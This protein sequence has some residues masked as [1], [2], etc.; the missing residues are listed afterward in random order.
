MVAL[1]PTSVMAA[2]PEEEVLSRVNQIRSANGLAALSSNGQLAQSAVNY[3]AYMGRANFFSHTGPDGST[4][5]GRIEAGGYS[6]WT[7]VAENL[8]G[9]QG[10]AAAVVDAWMNSPGH[11]ANILSPKAKELGIGHVFQGGSTYGHYWVQHFGARAGTVA[12]PPP[13]AR[14]TIPLQNR[15]LVPAASWTAPQTGKTVN[16][17]WL[18][19]MRSH[20]DVDNMGL[21][22]S[23]AMP[24]RTTGGQTVQVFQRSIVEFHPENSGTA[25]LQR[26][27]LGD[28]LFPGADAPTSVG[29][30]PPGSATYFP[31]SPDRPT[32]LGHWVAD[33]TRSGQPVY[34]KQ[35]FDSRGGV[36]TF[37]YPK[38]E[39]KLR[40]GIWTQ[41][42][43]AAVF[44][45]HPEFDRD[46]VNANGI[47][48]RN[49]RVQLALLGEQY[50]KSRGMPLD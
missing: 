35:Y 19:Y 5:T 20:G 25:R 21:P 33:Y 24:D 32:G 22:L 11:R 49:Y 23:G 40:D 38:E 26:R 27:L 14:E 48:W 36:D 4:M 42:F 7:F 10:S 16:G 2:T 9:G 12:A 31:F 30:T 13:P 34:F 1:A 15:I 8:A 29:D 43:Q 39:P 50:V 3:A 37:G 44:E 41:R 17:D 28:L 18:N 6:G 45:Y 47:P 46:G